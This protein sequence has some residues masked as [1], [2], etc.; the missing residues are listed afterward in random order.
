MRVVVWHCPPPPGL[1]SNPHVF[2]FLCHSE[3][4]WINWCLTGSCLLSL[5]LILLFRESYDRLYLDV[6]VSV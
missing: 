2:V 5:V 3:L 6:F 4:S 1:E